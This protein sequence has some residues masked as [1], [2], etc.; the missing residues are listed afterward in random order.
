MSKIKT[1]IYETGG[2]MVKKH[3]QVFWLAEA[4]ALMLY[5]LLYVITGRFL[6]TGGVIFALLSVI[7][8]MYYYKL[9]Y[10]ICHNELYISSGLIFRKHRRLPLNNILW[11]MRLTLRNRRSTGLP[12]RTVLTIF[13]TSGGRIVLFGEIIT[14]SQ[15]AG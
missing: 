13:H 1:E 8:Y 9:Q 10:T 5:I 4:A 3:W 2:Q 15:I 14:D 12:G 6:L 7:W 11:T